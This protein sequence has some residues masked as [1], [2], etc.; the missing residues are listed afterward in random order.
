MTPKKQ[1]S[2]FARLR[3]YLQHLSRSYGRD[4][5]AVRLIELQNVL[6]QREYKHALAIINDGHRV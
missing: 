3:V 2:R 4:I 6:S 1:N 5:A